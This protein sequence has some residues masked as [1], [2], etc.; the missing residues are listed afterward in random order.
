[1]SAAAHSPTAPVEPDPP[2]AAPA[3]PTALGR[4]LSVVRRLIDFG[5]KFAATVQ[6]RAT[7]PDIVFFAKRIGSAD[8]AVILA[9]ITN[10]LRLAAALEAKLCQRAARGQDLTPSPIRM[11]A[12]GKPRS[13]RQVAP[14]DTKP[15]HQPADPTQDPRLAR[16]PTEAE[17]AAEIRRR[18]IGAVIADICLDL[19]V[20]PGHLDRAFWDELRH[21]IIMY[22]G[23]LDCFLP[24]PKLRKFAPN[25][26]DHVAPDPPWSAPPPGPSALSTHPP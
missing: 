25:S 23:S 19:G 17:I 2:R 21:A 18:P 22:G 13:E 5:K 16:L 20:M 4:V 26:P 24:Y 11:P 1:M 6:Q 15:E 10:G 9:R 12:A 7:T 14:P 8:L 3:M